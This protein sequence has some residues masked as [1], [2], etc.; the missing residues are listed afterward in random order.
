M[1]AIHNNKHRAAASRNTAQVDCAP[2]IPE[3]IPRMLAYICPIVFLI[4]FENIFP[5]KCLSENNGKIQPVSFA[6]VGLMHVNLN[7]IVFILI[8][9]KA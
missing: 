7:I 1:A 4:E 5:E 6:I 3:D 2:R 9:P 8:V